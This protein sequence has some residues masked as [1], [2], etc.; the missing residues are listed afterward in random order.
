[1]HPITPF[2]TAGVLDVIPKPKTKPDVPI[3]ARPRLIVGLI[4]ADG[5]FAELPA[6]G[7]WIDLFMAS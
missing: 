3:I 7:F 4:K 6:L 5:F 2:A 1:V